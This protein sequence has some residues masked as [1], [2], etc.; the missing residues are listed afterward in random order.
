[1]SAPETAAAR[2]R[3]AIAV[4]AVA[5]FMALCLVVVE[6][7]GAVAASMGI[8]EGVKVSYDQGAAVTDVEL[9]SDPFYVL[10]IGSDSRK[11]TALYTGKSNEHA[12]VD[13]HSDIMTLLR[14]DPY[15]PQLTL[16]T[17][18]RDTV[19]EGSDTK[20]NE[21]L[22]ADNDPLA[23]VAQV[24]KL[25]GVEIEYYAMTTF[26]GFERLVDGIGGLTIDVPVTV[27]V[28]DPS[29]A[30]DVRV[31]AGE[32]KHLDGSEALVVAR[33]RKEYKEDE[34]A[35]R[36][37]N[38]RNLEEAIIWKGISAC[39][40]SGSSGTTFSRMMDALLENVTTN[41]DSELIRELVREISA[42]S[43]HLMTIYS[44]TGPHEGGVDDDIDLWIV[45]EDKQAWAELMEI[46]D[47][48]G[49]PTSLVEVPEFPE[50]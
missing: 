9:P 35:L 21:A 14:V 13:Q 48:G 1:M 23:V 18:P 40:D 41:M 31:T 39:L 7:V 3:A 20:I 29:N 49:D 33:A 43:D 45:E 12:Q 19:L 34:D 38:V 36:Q 25:T 2:K 22:A 4:A 47:A 24:E 46:V 16:V 37:A 5:V 50:R 32:D 26:I 30:E 11:G 6:I 17:V 44:C 28:P 8:R 42:G 10:L 15:T 27:T